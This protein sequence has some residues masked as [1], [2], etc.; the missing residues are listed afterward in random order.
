MEGESPAL[1]ERVSGSSSLPPLSYE[2]GRKPDFILPG[3]TD[4]VG[5]ASP[6]CSSLKERGLRERTHK[7]VVPSSVEVHGVWGRCYMVGVM[8]QAGRPEEVT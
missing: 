8:W 3:Q 6:Q 2:A 5:L 1:G 4:P 7:F